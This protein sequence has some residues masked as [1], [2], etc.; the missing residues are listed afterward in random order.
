VQ[1]ACPSVLAAKM[2]ILERCLREA[3]VH[4]A[5]EAGVGEV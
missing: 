2:I 3:E 5:V 1:V 4:V